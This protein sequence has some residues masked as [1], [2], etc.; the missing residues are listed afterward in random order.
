[1]VSGL[2]FKEQTLLYATAVTA[3]LT[4]GLLWTL[5]PQVH[6]F[7]DGQDYLVRVLIFAVVAFVGLRINRLYIKKLEENDY[8]IAFTNINTDISS[9]FISIDEDNAQEKID[10][11]LKKMG[12]FFQADRAY[13][14]L[15]DHKKKTMALTYQWQQAGLDPLSDRLAQIP[16]DRQGWW[17]KELADKGLISIMDIEKMPE[18]AEIEQAFLIKE[19]IKSPP[20]PSP[21]P[22]PGFTRLYGHRCP[23]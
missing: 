7:I 15:I 23:G 19:K 13:I 22:G 21:R 6:V 16:L 8:Q 5:R 11:L 20:G 3:V 2:A 4:Q 14:F 1:M 12:L 18:Q 10:G 17:S 9:D